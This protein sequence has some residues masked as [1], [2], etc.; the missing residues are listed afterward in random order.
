VRRVVLGSGNPHKAA[1]V[2]PLLA[3]AQIEVVAVGEVD[4][5]WSVEET[6][7]T[8]EENAAI[9]ARAAASRT[10]WTAVADDTGLFVDALGGAPGIHASRYAGPGAT[11]ADNVRKLLAALEGVAPERRTARFRTVAVVATP[12][13][14][15]AALEGVLEG[16]ILETP[17]GEGG[18]GYDPV[19]LVPEAGRS[20]AE[21]SLEEKNRLSHR[22]MAF[23]AVRAF[24]ARHPE[25][26]TEGEKPLVLRGASR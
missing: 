7:E 6:G 17:V 10:G 21:L 26:W 15:E 5:G 13:G 22:A 9:K 24:L 20:L 8:L 11:Y 25:W 4:P 18:F 3:A 16:R 23:A 1:E 12:D 14:R 2:R 19:F